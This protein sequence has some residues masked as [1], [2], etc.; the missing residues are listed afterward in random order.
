MS[1]RFV[2]AERFSLALIVRV[3]DLAL[4]PMRAV[5]TDFDQSVIGFAQ[6]IWQSIGFEEHNCLLLYLDN[7]LSSVFSL[8]AFLL[9]KKCFSSSSNLRRTTEGIESCSRYVIICVRSPAS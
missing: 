7:L 4:A 8:I 2:I 5:C 9:E 3:H 6:P 1:E